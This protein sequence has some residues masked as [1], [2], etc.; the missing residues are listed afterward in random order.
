MKRVALAAIMLALAISVSVR[1]SA[2]RPAAQVGN[3]LL[4]ALP[5]GNAVLLID[6][7]RVVSSPLWNTLTAQAKF[8]SAFD[9]IQA[10]L[11][12][13]G[14]SLSDMQTVAV[15]FTNADMNNPAIAVSGRFN[16]SVLLARLRA[17]ARVKLTSETYKGI[18]VFNVESVETKQPPTGKHE[19]HNTGGFA[20]FDAGT[21]VAGTPASVRASIDVKTGSR[22][23]IAQNAK[24][25]EGLAASGSAAVR[26]ALEMTSS[27]ASKLPTGQMGDFS[28]IKLIFGG[29]DVTT[30]VDINATLRNDTAEHARTLTTQL[31]SLLDM[32][33]GFLGA[34]K[35][36]KMASLVEALK[37]VTITGNDID[38]RV[39]GNLPMEV[40]AQLLR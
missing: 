27:L 20:F 30:G 28:S 35:D 5:D 32:A 21:V 14:L 10:E 4:N 31:N 34:S 19:R 9:K 26:F 13:V 12:E 23:S 7:Q 18:E 37:S 3:E 11:A 33:R 17:D 22:P 25:N 24:L 36:A 1:P 16:Q 40:L 29:V 6:V 38:V 2:A 8:R 39:T 15:A